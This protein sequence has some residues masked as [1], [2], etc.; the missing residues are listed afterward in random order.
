LAWYR[1]DAKQRASAIMNALPKPIFEALEGGARAM[2][3]QG[4]RPFSSTNHAFLTGFSQQQTLTMKRP[5]HLSFT[6]RASVLL[7]N[8]LN[9][10]LSIH[11]P[12]RLSHWGF[13]IFVRRTDEHFRPGLLSELP[14]QRHLPK[15][16]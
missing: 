4:G 8:V 7:S 5:V 10:R 6:I 2:L 11:R 12:R 9:I 14:V 3:P 15:L 16:Q 13:I 1:S